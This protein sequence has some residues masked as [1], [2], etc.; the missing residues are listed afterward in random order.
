MSGLNLGQTKHLIVAPALE[1]VGLGGTAAINLVTGTGLVESGYVYRKQIGS[2]PAV[3]L[4]QM[5]P[6]THD[7]CWRNFLAYRP[8]LQV[9][10]LHF[11]SGLKPSAD[12]L[13]WHDPYAAIMCRIKYKRDREALPD[14][15]DAAGQAQYHKRVYNTALGSACALGNIS[16][17][18]KAILA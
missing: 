1:A 6:F 2:G 4:W 14:A 13:L 3:G 12:L 10:I 16:D 7:D 9:P 5:E 11:L 18:A 15:D 8:D 17:F